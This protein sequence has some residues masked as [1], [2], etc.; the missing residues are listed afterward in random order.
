LQQDPAEFL[1]L[2]LQLCWALLLHN[3]LRLTQPVVMLAPQT[4]QRQQQQAQCLQQQ[5]PAE[6]LLL[7][8]CRALLLH[9]ALRLAQPVAMLAVVAEEQ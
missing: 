7:Q 1:L 8:L 6:L 4:Q 9:N 2:L 3:A 5:D